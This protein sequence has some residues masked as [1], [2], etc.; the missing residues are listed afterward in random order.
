MYVCIHTKLHVDEYSYIMYMYICVCMC[1]CVCVCVKMFTQ[2]SMYV[3][4][5]DLYMFYTRMC[6][7]MSSAWHTD[8]LQPVQFPP[9]FV[10]KCCHIYTC[11]RH[12]NIVCGCTRPTKKK[13]EKRILSTWKNSDVG[14]EVGKLA[15]CIDCILDL[16]VCILCSRPGG[17]SLLQTFLYRFLCA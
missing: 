8:S 9:F 17:L 2:S 7:S 3:Y 4:I 10:S 16:L 11:A 15:Q 14:S 12:T 5:H 1:M 6:V 13:N